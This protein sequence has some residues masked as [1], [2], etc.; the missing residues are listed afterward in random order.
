MSI[1][2]N[3][4][5]GLVLPQI[6]NRFPNG[7]DR[8]YDAQSL[9]GGESKVGNPNIAST[10]AELALHLKN[11]LPLLDEFKKDGQLTLA[12][13]EAAAKEKPSVDGSRSRV[14]SLA[15]EIVKRGALK[16]AISRTDGVI[17]VERV[18]NASKTLIDN[19]NA[20]TQSDNPY[21]GKSPSQLVAALQG[22]F[23][24]WRDESQDKNILF[25]YWKFRYVSTDKITEISQN[26]FLKDEK[27]EAKRD[28][29][30]GFPLYKYSLDDV[31]L[32]RTLIKTPGLLD[33]LDSNKANGT[34]PLG[35]LNHDGWLK[36]TSLERWQENDQKERDG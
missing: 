28:P 34:N 8:F 4:G 25:G 29:S 5:P 33:S 22:R 30:N 19:S 32:A 13:L 2:N 31:H 1:S 15:A 18:V 3:P 17:T 16:E 12:S 11:D 20:N 35:S 14:S 21:H 23:N 10:D 9:L 6:Y 24:D 27:G 36:N 26:P 7:G